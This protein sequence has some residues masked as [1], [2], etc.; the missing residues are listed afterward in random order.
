MLFHHHN[1]AKKCDI[2]YI[3]SLYFLN[4]ITS[5]YRKVFFLRFSCRLFISLT[6]IWA[7]RFPLELDQSN[8]FPCT[9]CVLI[10]RTLRPFG[11]LNS[12]RRALFHRSITNSK[13]NNVIQLIFQSYRPTTICRII[14]FPIV[15]WS[16]PLRDRISKNW[17]PRVPGSKA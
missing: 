10:F 7:R 5:R 13:R 2:L 4:L 11:F 17:P 14:V 12:A 3:M 1:F 8:T 6:F 9:P 15:V 16:L